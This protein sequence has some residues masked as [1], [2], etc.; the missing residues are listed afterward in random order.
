MV[1]EGIV[2]CMGGGG[3]G[4]GGWIG[5]C[6]LGDGGGVGRLNLLGLLFFR[7]EGFWREDRNSR[8]V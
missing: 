6:V 1:V 3:G 5:V 4:G 2:G 8:L 7:G